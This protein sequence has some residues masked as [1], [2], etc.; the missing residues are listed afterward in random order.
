MA[1][2][3]HNARSSARMHEKVATRVMKVGINQLIQFKKQHEGGSVPEAHALFSSE[4]GGAVVG[5]GGRANW[6][7]RGS[8][9][10][11]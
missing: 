3:G 9:G 8:A 6:L 4:E 2:Q 5:G 10:V 11:F 1:V 7:G